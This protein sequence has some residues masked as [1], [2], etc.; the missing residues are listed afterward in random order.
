MTIGSLIEEGLRN[1][2]AEVARKGAILV[3]HA[4]DMSTP[5]KVIATSLGSIMQ[6]HPSAFSSL[7]AVGTGAG[8]YG[9]G[10]AVMSKK[11]SQ[12]SLPV[13]GVAKIVQDAGKSLQSL[14]SDTISRSLGRFMVEH[15]ATIGYAGTVGA[16]VLGTAA[17]HNLTKKAGELP[18]HPW[19][20]AMYH[21][22]YIAAADLLAESLY[23]DVFHA[24]RHKRNN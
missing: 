14:S 12:A 17:I 23:S 13:V 4:G 10:S 8:I 7:E 9:V 6:K 20:Y 21:G 18:L 22:S 24:N 19:K 3:E 16:G 5:A 11:A 2:P 15:P 1:E